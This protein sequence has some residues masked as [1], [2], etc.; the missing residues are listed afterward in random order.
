MFFSALAVYFAAGLFV[1]AVVFPIAVTLP[2]RRGDQRVL[3]LYV[4]IILL[5]VVRSLSVQ[6]AV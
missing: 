1:V 5:V 2:L 4:G 6:T 3:S